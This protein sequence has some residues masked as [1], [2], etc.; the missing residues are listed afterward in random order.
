MYLVSNLQ[1]AGFAAGL[2]LVYMTVVA[3]YR[4]NF[5]PNAK[6][7]GPLLAKLTYWQAA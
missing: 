4:L 3:V 6:I 5:H 7:P 1:A 2:L